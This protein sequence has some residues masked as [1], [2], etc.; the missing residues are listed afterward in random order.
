MQLPPNDALQQTGLKSLAKSLADFV[1][2]TNAM[3]QAH[4]LAERHA[5]LPRDSFAARELVADVIGD[6]LD[7]GLAC[8]PDQAIA[9]QVESHVRRRANRLRKAE[10]P[11]RTRT[12]L[13]RDMRPIF[14]P[15]DMAP[16]SALLVD[17]LPHSLDHHT[18]DPVEL[19]ARIRDLVSGDAT[20][21]QLLAFY[22]RG[23][24]RREVLDAG[25]TEWAYRAARDRLAEYAT[26]AADAMTEVAPLVRQAAPDEREAPIT[27][28]S[29]VA[30]TYRTL[31]SRRATSRDG[32]A[33]RA[34]R[35][36]K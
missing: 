6:V 26:V 9:P 31:R 4:R 24:S 35:T 33:R 32:R 23:L 1:K 19:V 22:E 11:Q 2:D 29:T 28:M 17:A 34:R 10:N 14:V 8:R 7:G 25:M 18:L 27:A 3:Q 12:S 21:R 13:R 36:P 30:P 15:L 5:R 16:P 20:A